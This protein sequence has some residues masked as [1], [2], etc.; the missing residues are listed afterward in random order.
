MLLFTVVY[1]I[2]AVI[3]WSAFAYKVR[4]LFGDPRNRELQLL[5]LA[6]ATFAMPFVLASPHVY[7]GIDHLL[8]R[9]NAATLLVYICVAVC[10]TSF[11]ALLVS[12]SCAQ[13]TVRP[14]HR[15]L[16]AYSVATLVVMTLSFLLGDVSGPEHPIDFDVHF[17]L[18]P[19]ISVF[20]LSYQLLFSVSMGMLVV[21]CH[22]YAGVVDRPWLRRGLRL[23]TAGAVFGLGYSLPKVANT[24]WD[25]VGHSPLHYAGT[26]LAPMSAS[27]AAALFAV[28]FTMPAWGQGVTRAGE[29]VIAFR[30]YRR[31]YPLWSA[32]AEQFP[33]LVLFPPVARAAR[34]S[35]RDLRRLAGRQVVE[36][37]NGGL[38]LRSHHDPEVQHTARDLELLLNRQ[39]FE[40]RDAQLALRPYYTAATQRSVRELARARRLTGD[41]AEAVVEA[42][43]LA[44]ALRA[45]AEG[46]ALPADQHSSLHDAADGDLGEELAWLVRV[47]DAYR[48]SPVVRAALADAAHSPADAVSA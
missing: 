27:V 23:V 34:W 41:A 38:A 18:A 33:D 22:R 31:L 16:V 42:A 29:F 26:V 48:G 2:L 14:R 13:D 28:G 37:R 10:L 36:V 19:Y 30:S 20:L 4:D 17:E 25:E 24:L 8:G 3:T 7:T 44:V 9:P 46:R 35:P 1:G 11:V 21:L 47:A 5:C 43:Q 40:I 39:I 32:L 15:L 6:I 45:R 12:W